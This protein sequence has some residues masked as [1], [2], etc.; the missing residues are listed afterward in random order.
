M[1]TAILTV[2]NILAGRQLYDVWEVNQ[3][4]EYHEA[5]AAGAEAS[6]GAPVGD[7]QNAA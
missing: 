2:R 6:I 1:M 3:D 7:V 4:A 5:G